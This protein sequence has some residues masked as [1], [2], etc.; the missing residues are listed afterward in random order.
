MSSLICNYCTIKLSFPMFNQH[1][2]L[3]HFIQIN[4]PVEFKLKPVEFKLKGM[5]VTLCVGEVVG[6]GQVLLPRFLEQVIW[7]AQLL[8]QFVSGDNV[9]LIEVTSHTD[10]Y[11]LR[12]DM[13][14]LLLL[15]AKCKCIYFILQISMNLNSSE[16]R[17]NS[18]VLWFLT[19]PFQ[20]SGSPQSGSLFPSLIYPS[21]SSADP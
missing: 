15:G 10:N 8:D 13:W 16:K 7:T 5:K 9:N 3:L 14:V 11:T 19:S 6:R 18:S 20:D 21:F 2:R 4:K 1:W 17:L 12:C